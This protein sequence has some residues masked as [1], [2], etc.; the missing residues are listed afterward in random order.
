MNDEK[1]MLVAWVTFV[2]AVAA[3]A[4]TLLIAVVAP[5]RAASQVDIDGKPHLVLDPDDQRALLMLLN[6]K[7]A[8]IAVLRGE[9]AKVKKGCPAT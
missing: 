3:V 7:D 1:R 6:S 8:E 4:M 5:A 2:V 9:L